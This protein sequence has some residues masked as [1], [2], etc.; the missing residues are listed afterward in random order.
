M[1]KETLYDFKNACPVCREPAVS[2]WQGDGIGYS[3]ARINHK[4]NC[5][6]KKRERKITSEIFESIP[7][8][9]LRF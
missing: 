4:E 6:F 1:R 3:I 7:K 9:W 2:Y 5:E 8:K